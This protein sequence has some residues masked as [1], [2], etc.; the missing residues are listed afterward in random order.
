[1]RPPIVFGPS[2]RSLFP[3]SLPTDVPFASSWYQFPLSFSSVIRTWLCFVPVGKVLAILCP[4]P[5]I[6]PIPLVWFY[7]VVPFSP[8]HSLRHSHTV[9]SQC[10]LDWSCSFAPYSNTASLSSRSSERSTGVHWLLLQATHQKAHDYAT[11]PSLSL[12]L[13]AMS[14]VLPRSSF[15][16]S[17]SFLPPC[18]CELFFCGDALQLFLWRVP[19]LRS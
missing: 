19:G 3:K 10:P 8:K 2:W 7:L 5:L 16:D 15:F 6:F 14:S 4:K 13:N 11:W 9:L 17:T 1:M 18:P 12:W